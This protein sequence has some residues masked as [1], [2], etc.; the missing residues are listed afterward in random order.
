MASV[1]SYGSRYRRPTPYRQFCYCR[2][3]D[4]PTWSFQ[5]ERK[6]EQCKC[7]LT[8]ARERRSDGE[9]RQKSS[10]RWRPQEGVR[11][12]MAIFETFFRPRQQL[13]DGCVSCH[14]LW[15]KNKPYNKWI[16][17]A[18]GRKL[19]KRFQDANTIQVSLLA[20]LGNADSQKVGWDPGCFVPK[21]ARGLQNAKVAGGMELEPFGRQIWRGG[22]LQWSRWC[23]LRVPV[24]AERQRITRKSLHQEIARIA[25]VLNIPY[26][27][28]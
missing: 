4:S 10:P 5:A 14:T 23:E 18:C 3:S 15:E 26:A 17:A 19:A 6:V 9:H 2:S 8:A 11:S 16:P 21:H 12:T 13:C 20:M 7:R 28:G 25:A 1:R 22:R 24:T 27:W